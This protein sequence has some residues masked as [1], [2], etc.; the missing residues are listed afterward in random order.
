MSMH[1][2]RRDAP[3]GIW[4]RAWDLFGPDLV[5]ITDP[6]GAVSPQSKLKVE[7][8][9][10]APGK[11]TTDGWVGL[12]RWQQMVATTADVAQWQRWPGANVGLHMRRHVAFDVDL[13]DNADDAT[14]NVLRALLLVQFG[15]GLLRTRPNSKRF[16]AIYRQ[17]PDA[18]IV[19][20]RVVWLTERSTGR[21][22]GKVEVLTTGQQ[23]VILGQHQ[24]G[25]DLELSGPEG[26]G[27]VVS[28]HDVDRWVDAL[29]ARCPDWD[30][31]DHPTPMAAAVRSTVGDTRLLAAAGLD[32][33]GEALS[34]IAIDG[35]DYDAWITVLIAAKMASG[36]DDDFF[37]RAVLPWC[38][39]A[40]TWDNT[41]DSVRE[42][43]DS[44]KGG[45]VGADLI[46]RMARAGGWQ[47]VPLGGDFGA[48]AGAAAG[49][50]WLDPGRDDA[51]AGPAP[52]PADVTAVAAHG[53]DWL[54]T[55]PPVQAQ[56]AV[57]SDRVVA[58]AVAASRQG[59]LYLF[60]PWIGRPPW[61]RWDGGRWQQDTAGNV[62]RMV[63]DIA[64][65]QFGEK[66]AQNS[67][68]GAVLDLLGA[69]L[70]AGMKD[71]DADPWALNTPDGIVD[72]RTGRVRA[73]TPD[74]RVMLQTR[75]G[76][77]DPDLCPTWDR[78]LLDWANGQPDLADSIVDVLAAA[79]LGQP[80]LQRFF[81][82]CGDGAN[83]KS[84]LLDCMA[85]SSGLL[86]DY[87]RTAD[88]EMLQAATRGGGGPRNDI[89]R[90]RGARFITLIEPRE[91]KLDAVA[92]KAMTGGDD[93][94]VRNLFA[95]ERVTF[96]LGALF[97]ATNG[98]LQ[99]DRLDA[100]WARRMVVLPFDTTFVDDGSGPALK[101]QLLSEG[102]HFLAK[103]IERVVRTGG[104]VTMPDSVKQATSEALDDVDEHR[105][106]LRAALDVTAQ[107]DDVLTW[108]QILPALRAA[109]NDGVLG[110][111]SDSDVKRNLARVLLTLPG[112]RRVRPWG[113]KENNGRR[114]RVF[115]GVRLRDL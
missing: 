59:R 102:N 115:C 90:L 3:A 36:G 32:A 106:L 19:G 27:P 107:A 72:L 95:T 60:A 9:G 62:R 2:W 71:F 89:F 34:C 91:N 37:D 24:S 38:L 110:M 55:L 16:A 105:A 85:G 114:A 111:A 97:I 76:V 6:R 8:L 77:G 15:P 28:T 109:D 88:R 33:L 29:M 75:T 69:S 17:S 40:V 14:A 54:D 96:K 98:R 99:P 83:G 26:D 5:P 45:S 31:R 81:N 46:D 93:V 48:P 47:G 84:L 53:D 86:G 64:G 4:K 18:P 100:A 20:K 11:W 49:D 39:G 61:L 79:L 50:G 10:K 25:A 41:P 21:A 101:A 80:V 94:D 82:L 108:D 35:L 73:A 56:P 52:A 65:D 103:L 68:A 112:V 23:L 67:K 78:C 66:Y 57:V 42:K 113:G 43:W 104:R 63:V 12:S 30:V 70:H 7:N 51:P 22:L 58:D 44:I 87:G 74:D 1:D 92:L 13:V